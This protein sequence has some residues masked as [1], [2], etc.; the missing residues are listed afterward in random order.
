MSTTEQAAALPD[1]E[2]MPV[3]VTF[4]SRGRHL[5]LER[6]HPRR[7]VDASGNAVWQKGVEYEFQEGMLVVYPGQ[8]KIADK[9]DA[10]TGQ[11]HEQDAIE[12]LRAQPMYGHGNGFWE[13]AP[14]AP[15]PAP[16]LRA[17]MQMAVAAGNPETRDEA[18]SRLVAV[19]EREAG[20]W[21]RQ[22]VLDA[23]KTALA[24]IESQQE[25]AEPES[26][27]QTAVTER[28]L[29]APPPP[30]PHPD[31]IPHSSGPKP[32]DL[33][34]GFNPVGGIEAAPVVIEE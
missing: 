8:D 17:I 21:Q 6:V 23:A 24:A 2:P 15:D 25:L 20:S 27:E 16:D 34:A 14:V 18:E 22:A 11:M 3:A 1:I 12:W 28:D 33:D 31:T 13:V 5:T 30:K 10:T 4:A 32:K 29:P 7:H 9:F 19:Y 26:H